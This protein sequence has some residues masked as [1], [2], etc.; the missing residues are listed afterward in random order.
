MRRRSR[1][2]ERVTVV[3]FALF[4]VAGVVGVAFAAGY[5]L[6]RLLL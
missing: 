1:L 6:G 2:R 5:I 3:A 4:V